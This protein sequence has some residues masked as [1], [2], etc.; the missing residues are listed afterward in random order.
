VT[1]RTPFLFLFISLLTSVSAFSNPSGEII[2]KWQSPTRSIEAVVFFEDIYTSRKIY[3]HKFND[4]VNWVLLCEYE[5]D[6]EI[7][8]SPNEEWIAMND[9]MV[10]NIASI[11]MFKRKSQLQYEE[12]KMDPSTACWAFFHNKT[13]LPYPENLDHIYSEVLRWSP[14]SK[15]I[16]INLYGHEG[17]KEVRDWLCVYSLETGKA[18]LKL[19]LMNR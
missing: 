10:S 8:F 18:S 16:L 19:S 11:R 2:K 17:N 5:R 13:K 4:D 9:Y 15:T 3:L 6:A 14:D 12:T 7:I 1:Q